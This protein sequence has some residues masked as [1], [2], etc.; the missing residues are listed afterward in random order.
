LSSESIGTKIIRGLTSTELSLV[1]FGLLCAAAI[2][3]TVLQNRATY[4]HHPLFLALLVSFGVHLTACTVRRWR[5]LA[6]STLIVHLG[7]LVILAGAVMTASGYVATINIHEGATVDTVYRWD[8]ERDTPLGLDITISRINR[9]YYPIPLKIGIL[10]G[11]EKKD[12]IVCKT[13]ETFPLEGFTVHVDSYDPW[14]GTLRLTLLEKGVRLGTVDSTGASTLPAGFPYSF[15]LVAFQDPAIKRFWTELQLSRDGQ[16]VARGT[17][18]L[19]KPFTW[20]GLYFFNPQI[21]K[22][23]EGVPYA[24]I[25]IVRD[26]G[27]VVVFGG[28]IVLSVGALAA[29]HRRYRRD[30][31]AT[32]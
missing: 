10:K 26:P 16:V 5:G 32:K 3:G 19:N 13:G 12:L 23:E 6:R 14:D 9:E 1:L 18:E 15:Q 4:Y 25:Q 8:L 21:A 27:Q 28:M 31:R 22:D 24:G 11:E 20:N 7:V 29:W 2:P 17:T 30:R